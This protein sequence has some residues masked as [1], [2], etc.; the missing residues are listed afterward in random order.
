M[1]DSNNWGV[2]LN[3]K[4]QGLKEEGNTDDEFTNSNPDKP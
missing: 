2:L 3:P 4:K 1:I